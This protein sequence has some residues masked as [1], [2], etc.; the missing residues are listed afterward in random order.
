MIL[1]TGGSGFIGQH[2]VHRIANDFEVL[3]L[4]KSPLPESMEKFQISYTQVDLASIESFPS[5]RNINQIVH[6]AAETHNDSALSRP[7]D[8]IESNIIGTFNLIQWATEH[9][10]PLHHVST[11]EVF[12]DT[13]IDSDEKFTELT[14]YKP[15][16]PYSA[17]KAS[18]DM[19]V[20]AWVR[21]FG[22]RA[23]ISNTSNNYG[24]FQSIEKLIPRTAHLAMNGIAPKIYGEGK[25][26][27][28][29][30]HVDDHVEGILA[31]LEKG[32]VGETYLLGAEC[33]RSNLEVVKYI[34]DHFGLDEN[35]IDFVEDRPGHDRRYAIDASK[36]QKD[37]GWEPSRKVIE[38]HLPEVLDY[39]KQNRVS[40]EK[41]RNR[42][43]SSI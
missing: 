9:E 12:G 10:I 6:F 29:W 16:S 5:F 35:F 34:L 1:V 7:S 20:R 41:V 17:S 32:K 30:I 33:Q 31:V 19:L 28:D 22:L 2:F 42:G 11:D 3:V 15:S 37:L 38:E 14:P 26:I 24:K 36:A 27:R 21:S 13:E 8:F 4:D 39:Y 43:L 23:T 25:N 18:S 40:I